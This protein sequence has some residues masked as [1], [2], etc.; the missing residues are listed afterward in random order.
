MKITIL[1]LL[2]AT[3]CYASSDLSL[4]SLKVEVNPDGKAANAQ[5][6]FAN[7]GPEDAS[8][9]G[10]RLTF[11]SDGK[12]TVS[13][14]FPLQPLAHDAQRSETLS[15]E[16]TGPATVLRAEIYDSVQPDIRPSNNTLESKVR[17]PG[18]TTADLAIT[19]G[20][21]VSVQPVQ[22]K[23]LIVRVHLINRGPETV[24]NTRATAELMLYQKTVTSAV[25]SPGRISAGEERDQQFS[26]A[27]P[28]NVPTSEGIVIVRWLHTDPDM[29]DPSIS[30]N[31]Y[32]LPV[33]LLPRQPDLVGG[34]IGVNAHGELAF[35]VRNRGNAPAAASTTVLYMNGAQVKRYQT[36]AIPAGGEKMHHYGGS[37]FPS[38]TQFTIVLDYNAEVP[39]S[40]KENNRIQFIAK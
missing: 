24:T 9:V 11:L 4:T 25:R 33:N 37:K 6:V 17:V 5:I 36:P 39:E 12:E 40:S 14:D 10:V 15:M 20:T 21:V 35:S 18:G 34:N 2:S 32:S 7:S 26:L 29:Q 16:L 30:D 38:G 28:S 31:S 8:A 23:S 1:I 13:Q 22:D 19:D 3:I 27:I